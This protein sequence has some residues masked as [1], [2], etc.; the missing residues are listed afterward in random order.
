MRLPAVIL[1]VGPRSFGPASQ[2]SDMVLLFE[3][4]PGV[5][6]QG[7]RGRQCKVQARPPGV[8]QARKENGR[9]G[10]HTNCLKA[11]PRPMHPIP[12]SGKNQ[13]ALQLFWTGHSRLLK[14]FRCRSSMPRKSVASCLAVRD[15]RSSAAVAK[16]ACPVRSGVVILEL[17]LE[18]TVPQWLLGF[19]LGDANDELATGQRRATIQW[20]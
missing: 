20:F 12:R 1:K 13:P 16:S 5:Q 14:C 6:P 17:G 10:L 3:S 9:Q 8:R 18:A 7:C 15:S 4:C 11:G 2:D 19:R